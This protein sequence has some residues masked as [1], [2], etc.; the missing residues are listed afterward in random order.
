MQI[1]D[2]VIAG[3]GPAGLSAAL[4]L[5]RCLRKVL[6]CD[7]GKPRNASS[8]ASWGF[9]TRDGTPP[10]E[11]LR[12]AREQLIP[13][14]VEFRKDEIIDIK[15]AQDYFIVDTFSGVQYYS[16]KILIA[17]GV[18]DYLPEIPDVQ[19]YYGKSI[20]HCPYCDGWQV[21]N[22]PLVAYGKGT[23]A[24]GMSLSLKTWS[25]NVT[26]CTDTNGKYRL[27]AA[28]ISKLA[29]N[30]I[31]IQTT[32]IIRLEGK[33]SQLETIHFK[34]GTSISCNAIFFSLGFNQHSEV[35]RKLNCEFTS[36]GVI[37]TNNSQQTSIPGVYAAGDADRDMQ[38]VVIAAAEGAKAGININK[39]LQKE[40]CL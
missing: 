32:K 30:G 36:R 28:D 35:A 18:K 23:V 26:L 19:K 31:K 4:V 5:G 8:D 9:L 22:Q 11:L 20:H 29:R 15:R 10:Q 17:T 6:I 3:G 1:Y 21:R 14:G 16:K 33:N 25:N 39:D 37:K 13:Y 38:Q 7:T 40:T 24:I 2:V 12:I 34:D 27:S